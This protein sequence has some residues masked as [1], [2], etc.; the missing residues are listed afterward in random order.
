MLCS[1]TVD[2]ASQPQ[3]EPKPEEAQAD[4]EPAHNILSDV[5]ERLVGV[6]VS[7]EPLPG[8]AA[9]A[10]AEPQG[11]G[12]GAAGQAPPAPPQANQPDQPKWSITNLPVDASRH[13]FGWSVDFRKVDGYAAAGK[14]HLLHGYCGAGRGRTCVLHGI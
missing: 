4:V 1:A 10:L 2:A 11:E 7:G 13:T 14:R 8:P 9:T 6:R 12:P 3:A 5:A